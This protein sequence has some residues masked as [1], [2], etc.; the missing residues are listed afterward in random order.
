LPPNQPNSRLL[1]HP[2]PASFL[3]LKLQA[4][5][6][7]CVRSFSTFPWQILSLFCDFSPSELNHDSFYFLYF[8]AATWSLTCVGVGLCWADG[9]NVGKTQAR[10]IALRH[11]S[12]VGRPVAHL[13]VCSLVPHL[14]GAHSSGLVPTEDDG[15]SSGWLWQHRRVASS[16]AVLLA[17][18]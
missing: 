4:C 5:G 6:R 18:W 2:D 3:T 17:Y 12:Y 11:Y 14:R 8:F 15:I 7:A 10:A 1:V 9:E 13:A 16:M